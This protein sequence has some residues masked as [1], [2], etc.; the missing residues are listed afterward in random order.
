MYAYIPIIWLAL[1]IF[2][3]LIR[4]AYEVG[5]EDFMSMPVPTYI[6]MTHFDA[7]ELRDQIMYKDI[8][9][10][11]FRNPQHELAKMRQDIVQSI[12]NKTRPFITFTKTHDVARKCT[13]VEAV[14]FV[15]RKR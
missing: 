2:F 6:E 8:A 7:V 11:C 15:G 1:V 14:L 10:L 5:A 3:G 9:L 4:A 13:R 12:L